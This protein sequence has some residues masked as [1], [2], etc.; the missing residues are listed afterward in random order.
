MR[1]ANE[2]I[3]RERHLIPTVDEV[4]QD[5]TQSSAVFTKLDLKWG[6]HQLKL[7]DESCDI[8][9]FTTHAGLYR[10]KR[11]MFG[12]TSA[13]KIYQHVIQQ[14]LHRCEGVRNISDDIIL[15][16]K[17]D[18]QHDERLEK[19]LER[20]QQRGLTL[21]PEKCK[22]RMAQ[23]ELMGYLLSTRDIGPTES[24]VEAVL[25]TR[26]PESVAE[27]RSFLGLVNFSVKFFPNLATVTEP[28]RQLT[29]KG[30]TFK[31]SKEQQEA[32]QALKGT[33]A[34]PEMLAYY[35]KDAKTRVI[36]DAS[37]VGLHVGEVLV[38][39]QDGH[40]RSVYYAS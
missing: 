34:S 38:Q 39:E 18:Q 32:F 4:L 26:E 27:V 33:L 9:T 23:L 21:N 15:H 36:A 11:L 28:L 1:K 7:S 12:I 16:A 29:R 35:D 5:M 25:N 13:P 37:H 8:T 20:L 14:A 24:K 10:Y 17:N 2:A 31:W 19:L 6:Y 40:W 30:V 3:L 22:F